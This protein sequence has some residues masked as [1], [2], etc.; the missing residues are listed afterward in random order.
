MNRS[1]KAAIG[2]C[3]T[4]TALFVVGFSLIYS[5]EYPGRLHWCSR[6][7]IVNCTT[8]NANNQSL[9]PIETPQT[10]YNDVYTVMYNVS[11]CLIITNITLTDNIP[12]EF[13]LGG[14]AIDNGVVCYITP[15]CEID[16]RKAGI[17]LTIMVLSA[18]M[19]ATALLAFIAATILKFVPRRYQSRAAQSHDLSVVKST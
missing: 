6:P 3:A 12:C 13:V 11:G 16:S 17:L 1:L 2:V 10:T 5:L 4:A 15:E 9:D 14:R 19:T 7:L 8:L 18:T